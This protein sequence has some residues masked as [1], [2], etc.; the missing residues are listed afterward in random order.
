M[1][2]LNRRGVDIDESRGELAF[3]VASQ[4]Q[5]AVLGGGALIEIDHAVRSRSAGPRVKRRG[6]AIIDNERVQES[7]STRQAGVETNAVLLR[8][9]GSGDRA[10][11]GRRHGLNATQER[12]ATAC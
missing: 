6:T 1:Q 12:W 8:R 10:F 3:K 2:H 11:N 9:S 4:P 5:A 7:R